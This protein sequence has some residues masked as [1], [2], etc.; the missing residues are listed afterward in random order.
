MLDAS[1]R[2]LALLS[3]LQARPEWSAAEL[4]A[5]LEITPRTVRRDVDK[6][7]TLGYPVAATRGVGG[8]YRLSQGAQ[9]PPLLLDDDEALAV[10]VALQS[11][12]TATVTGLGEAA[13]S[14][15]AKLRQV[16]PTRIRHRLGT[17]DIEVQATAPGPAV[18]ADVLRAVAQA[19]R[20]RERL[21][22]DYVRRSADGD[23]EVPMRRDT[24]PHQVVRLGSRW[25][26][27][28]FDVERGD[29]RTYRIDRM[30]PV[31]PTG[32]RFIPRPVPDGGAAAHVQRSVDRVYRQAAARIEILAPLA[33]IAPIVQE[34]WG[35]VESGGPDS[36]VVTVWSVSVPQI[37][38]WLTRFDR[39]FRVLE[40]EEL[41]AECHAI[42]RRYLDA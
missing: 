9:M 42:G 22:F 13:A 41:R 23:A 14:A 19:C 7:R 40:P 2:L 26:L 34:R 30:A 29:W 39:P 5:R 11:E 37:A 25:Y 20:A 3:L 8:G 32:P 10:A 35:A 38:H 18:N 31:V 24:E 28:G 16:M 17:V 33:E 12:A 21:R 15:L 27:L 36:C 6:L 4:A 1:A